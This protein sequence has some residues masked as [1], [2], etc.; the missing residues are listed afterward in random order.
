[1][2]KIWENIDGAGVSNEHYCE[3]MA[4][5]GLGVDMIGKI[6]PLSSKGHQWILAVTEYFTKWCRLSL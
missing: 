6:N 3:T 5:Q 2:S 1:M 4:I